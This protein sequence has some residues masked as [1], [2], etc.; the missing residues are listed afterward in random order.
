MTGGPGIAMSP[1]DRPLT[2]IAGGG[3]VPLHVAR[4]GAR[5]GRRVMIV[6]IEGEAEQEIS[7]FP[8]DWFQWGQLARLENVLASHGKGDIV[9]V[10]GVKSHPDFKRIKLDF[11][12]VKMLPRLLS[13]MASGD[14]TIL[15]GAI[16]LVESWG[17]TVIGAHEIA[18]D[19]VAAAGTLTA[20]RP[21]AGDLRDIDIAMI[22]A[23]DIGALD[24]GQAAVSVNGRLAALEAAEGT[25]GV[26][27]RVAALR[28][29][30][31][32]KWSGRVG[33]LAKC[34]KPQQDLRV[35]MPTIGPST[36]A[37]VEAAGLAGI[38]IEAGRVMIV[39]RDE[40]RRRADAL[41]LFI[42]AVERAAAVE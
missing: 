16:R 18:T 21:R 37:G 30:G 14:N 25:D 4:A 1:S 41:G 13:L 22:A 17:H 6:G 12:A 35:D 39:D 36:V 5:V 9:L 34:P 24:A 23:R 7:E 31:R 29:V 40:T 27:D 26:L 15:T 11:G 28:E 3:S 10:G 38:A 20:R 2:I 33:V 19:L 32:L 42:H 8:H